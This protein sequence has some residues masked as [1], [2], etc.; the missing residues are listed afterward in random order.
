MTPAALAALKAL[1]EALCEGEP[2]AS[3]EECAAFWARE[4][5]IKRIER[6]AREERSNEGMER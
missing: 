4:N 1:V 3:Y 5:E 2:F 6:K